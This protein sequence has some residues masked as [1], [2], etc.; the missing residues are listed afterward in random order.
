MWLTVL[1]TAIAS[2]VLTTLLLGAYWQRVARPRL[3]RDL[4]RELGARLEKG[5]EILEGRIEKAVR[6]GVLEGV[7]ALTSKEVLQDTTRSLAR[8]GAE[9][10]ESR[11]NQIFGRRRR[12]DSHEQRDEHRDE[13][14]T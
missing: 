13:G 3:E 8:S 5:T 7:A 6:R 2:A 10:V 12:D 9:I 4:K 1:L 14:D 11:I